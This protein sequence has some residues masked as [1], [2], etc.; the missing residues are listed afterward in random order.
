[1]DMLFTRRIDP[2]EL[3]AMRYKL[4]SKLTVRVLQNPEGGYTAKVLGLDGAVVTQ[5]NSGVELMTMVNDA[6]LTALDIPDR[7]RPYLATYLPEDTVREQFVT[8]IPTK[9]LKKDLELQTV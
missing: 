3:Y 9:F 4:P 2:D 5:A 1:M 7:Y 6:I 8:T